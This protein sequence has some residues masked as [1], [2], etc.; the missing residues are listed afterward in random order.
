MT[1]RHASNTCF[2]V[3]DNNVIARSFKSM[4]SV[5]GD[6]FF[7]MLL[8]YPAPSFGRARPA[9]LQR[10]AESHNLYMLCLFFFFIR[11]LLALLLLLLVVELILEL[12]R[13]LF[14]EVLLLVVV[15]VVVDEVVLV[16]KKLM[17]PEVDIDEVDEVDNDDVDSS[18][19]GSEQP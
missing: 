7:G 19:S 5:L 4:L 2:S 12:L 9:R 15:V 11:C 18:I 14:D 1:V 13:L 8:V 6:A 10:T 17:E 16:Y 3:A